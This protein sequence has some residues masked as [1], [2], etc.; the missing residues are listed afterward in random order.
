MR[1]SKVAAIAVG[2]VVIASLVVSW[3]PG[4]MEAVI[5]TPVVAN[6]VLAVKVTFYRQVSW[7]RPSELGQFSH[8]IWRYW[9]CRAA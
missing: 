8:L 1:C 3:S 4:L 2:I 9:R 6:I 5:A 7:N